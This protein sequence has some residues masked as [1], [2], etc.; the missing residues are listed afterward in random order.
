MKEKFPSTTLFL[1]SFALFVLKPRITCSTENSA[2]PWQK[3]KTSN[4]HFCKKFCFAFAL[5]NVP[6]FVTYPV[7]DLSG[8]WLCFWGKK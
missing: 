8:G 4:L 6:G 1:A 2:F 7:T 5:F 3:K